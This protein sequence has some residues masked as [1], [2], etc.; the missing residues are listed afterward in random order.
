[1][2]CTRVERIKLRMGILSRVVRILKVQWSYAH[3]YKRLERTRHERASLLSCGRAAQAHR[4]VLSV[5]L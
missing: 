4:S 3:V 5:S 2:G 1:M